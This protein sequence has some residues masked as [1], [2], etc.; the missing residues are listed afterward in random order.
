M[1]AINAA[2]VAS[3]NVAAMPSGTSATATTAKKDEKNVRRRFA[4]TEIG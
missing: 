3:A 2:R 4:R 1:T